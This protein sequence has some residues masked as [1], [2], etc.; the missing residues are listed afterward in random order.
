MFLQTQVPVLERRDQHLVQLC[1]EILRGY[2]RFASE[3]CRRSIATVTSKPHRPQHHNDQRGL[4]PRTHQPAGWWEMRWQE[5]RNIQLLDQKGIESHKEDRG[6]SVRTREW[7]ATSPSMRLRESRLGHRNA[8]GG[9]APLLS[10]L[11]I[12]A[13][14]LAKET[15]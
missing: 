2:R 1:T 10:W 5:R 13:Q 4:P 15:A 3:D 8:Q 7:T 11:A 12:R 9:R 14:G 6:E